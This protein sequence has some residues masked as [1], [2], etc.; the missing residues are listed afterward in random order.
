MNIAEF[1][2]GLAEQLMNAQA[3]KALELVGDLDEVAS[4]KARGH[5]HGI[6]QARELL[7][8]HLLQLTE[9]PAGADPAAEPPREEAIY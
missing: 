7:R 8:D 2:N 6:A 5:W 4:A 3:T 9:P 1:A